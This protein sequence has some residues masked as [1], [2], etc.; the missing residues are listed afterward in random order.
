[1]AGGPGLGAQA[2][3]WSKCWSHWRSFRS[4]CSS[5]LRAA[6]QGTN[7]VGELRSRLLAGWVAENLLAEHRARGDWLPLG[8]HR[9]T[10]REGGL[11]FAW[12]EEVIATPNAAFRRIDVRVFARRRG[13]AFAGAPRRV[14]RVFAGAAP[15]KPARTRG[16]TLIEVMTALLVLSLLA[17]MSYR[18]LGAVLDAREHVKQETDKW[19]RVAA[20]FRTLRARCRTCGAAPGAHSRGGT[21]PAWHGHAGRRTRRRA[22]NSAALPR[23]RAWTRRAGSAY[24]LNEKNEIELWLWPGLDVAPDRLPERYPVLSGVKVRT[25]VSR[26]RSGL[27]GQCV[28][29]VLPGDAAIPQAVRLRMVLASNEEIVRIFVLQH[30][31]TRQCGVAIVLA[32]GVVA[33]AAMAAAAIMVSQ[34]TWARQ[35]ELTTDHVQ[36]RGPCFRPAWIGPAPCLPTTAA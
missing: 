7:N 20:F 29:R 1:M 4:R 14:L 16:F 5:A 6:G 12:R 34:S 24:R 21:A 33:L 35:V 10:T 30:M 26:C 23:P 13:I 25:A 18:G 28:A 8:I 2:L 32:M 19:R 11:E 17:L 9:G 31:R 22:W 36:A 15:M 3:R 27:G